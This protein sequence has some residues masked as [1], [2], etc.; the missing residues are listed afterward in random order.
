MPAARGASRACHPACRRKGL[1]FA[2]DALALIQSLWVSECALTTLEGLPPLA[3]LRE[4]TLHGNALRDLGALPALPSLTALSVAGNALAALDA[5]ALA[6][7]PGLTALDASRN[8][9]DFPGRCLQA[10]VAAG[11]CGA[12]RALRLA[13]NPAGSVRDVARLAGLPALQELTWR[14]PLWGAAPVAELPRARAAALAALAPNLRRLDGEPADGAAAAEAL[15]ATEKA[16]SPI[17]ADMKRL[18][19]FSFPILL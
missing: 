5:A 4:L 13:G 19:S 2:S 18:P 7:V 14:S 12:L 15:E 3:A 8:R 17:G 10:A 9:L 6:R 11:G 1:P 16:R